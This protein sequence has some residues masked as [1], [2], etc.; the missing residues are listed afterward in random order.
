MII[1]WIEFPLSLSKY[2]RYI[3]LFW[4]LKSIS[5]SWRF[6]GSN[7]LTILNPIKGKQ[8]LNQSEAFS[9]L[10]QA[11]VVVAVDLGLHTPTKRFNLLWLIPY[12]KRYRL[13]LIEVFAASFL[14]QIFALATPLLFQQIIDRVI[15]KGATDALVPFGILMLVS[16]NHSSLTYSTEEHCTVSVRAYGSGWRNSHIF[17]FIGSQL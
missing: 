16:W 15:S 5:I 17:L 14:T 7:S 8:K 2:I 11:P 6:A 4:L 3:P 10:S 9:L 13:Q 12:I 1:F